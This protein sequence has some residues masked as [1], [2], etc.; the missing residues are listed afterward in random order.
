MGKPGNGKEVRY[1]R[2]DLMSKTGAA[3]NGPKHFSIADDDDDSDSELDPLQY[4]PLD[5]G[6]GLVQSLIRTLLPPAQTAVQLVQVVHED[7]FPSARNQNKHDMIILKN[8][9]QSIFTHF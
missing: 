5:D 9:S 2:V 4:L 6:G 1:H 7:H 3:K 8:I